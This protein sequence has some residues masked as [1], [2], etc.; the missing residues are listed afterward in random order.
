[1][2]EN[3]PLKEGVRIERIKRLGFTKLKWFR[4]C[5][6]CKKEWEVDEG[7]CCYDKWY[8]GECGGRMGF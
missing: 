3:D 2:I 6:G 5:S 7:R 1:M 8:C 4:I